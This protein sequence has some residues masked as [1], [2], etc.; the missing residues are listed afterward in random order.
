MSVIG[1]VHSNVFSTTYE[2]NLRNTRESKAKKD[3]N[4]KDTIALSNLGSAGASK[5]VNIAALKKIIENYADV[6]TERIAEIKPQIEKGT[7][8]ID[9]K[10][11]KIV[12][13]VIDETL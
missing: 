1:Q 4:L 11:D 9:D 2:P 13:N 5:D 8:S 12:E 3:E 10:V 6:R 7:Y